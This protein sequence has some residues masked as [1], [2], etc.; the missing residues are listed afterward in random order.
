VP[1]AREWRLVIV[2][3][4][5]SEDKGLAAAVAEGFYFVLDRRELIVSCASSVEEAVAE[6][7]GALAQKY[8][9]KAEHMEKL[10]HKRKARI[11]RVL[12]E[13]YTEMAQK[14]RAGEAQVVIT[15]EFIV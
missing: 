4:E 12:S 13:H 9:E 10:G 8:I 14:V 6:V 3:D 15:E 2:S 1:V 5:K 7:Y 11:F